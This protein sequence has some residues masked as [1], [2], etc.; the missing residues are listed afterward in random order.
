[1][2]QE[3]ISPIFCDQR[4]FDK[5]IPMVAKLN[6]HRLL[7]DASNQV[8]YLYNLNVRDSKRRQ[9]E[10][11][12]DKIR[13]DLRAS[14]RDLHKS[15]KISGLV[16]QRDIGLAG[17][18]QQ[19]RPRFRMQGSA[20]Y[21]TLNDPAKKPPQQVDFD[22]GV[23]VPT[24]FIGGA[25]KNR[26][27]LASKGYFRAVEAALEPLCANEGWELDRTKSSCVRVQ[28]DTD[29]HIDLP[30][31]AIPDNEFETLRKSH[32][33]PQEGTHSADEIILTEA[34]YRALPQDRV[35]LAHRKDGWIE[36]D[37]RKIEDWF[38]EALDD[39]GDALRY[40][41]RY[42]KGWRDFQWGEPCLS[43]IAIMKCV[44]VAYDE[45]GGE[46]AENR[47]DVALL[48]ATKRLPVLLSK[49]IEN[50]VIK[51]HFLDADWTPEERE[52]IV[53]RAQTLYDALDDALNHNLHKLVAINTLRKLF[54]S[55][56]PN[57]ET[58]LSIV[59]AEDEV[60]SYPAIQVAAPKVAR[61]TSG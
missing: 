38:K 2:N 52:D 42:V 58:L 43:S 23:F 29:A 25:S 4:I 35:M 30:L 59:G 51:G 27:L 49:P 37:P 26:P 6:A 50:P 13:N 24:S 40:V 1:L 19:L 11:A 56:I 18:L 46:V 41:C 7:R 47:D 28:I 57:D 53:L 55:R 12:R 15:V 22:D 17:A 45:L 61:S 44:I 54:G 14:F 9:L 8:G 20:A 34:I 36:S 32:G 33:S 21:H 48:M 16:E 31:Y 5:R 39:H 3:L 10:N 60:L